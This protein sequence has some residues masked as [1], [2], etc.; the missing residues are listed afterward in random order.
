MK[1]TCKRDTQ[2]NVPKQKSSFMKN[3]AA[4]LAF[5]RKVDFVHK[6]PSLCPLLLNKSRVNS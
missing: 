4:T 5:L 1:T 3:A 2:K 6:Q